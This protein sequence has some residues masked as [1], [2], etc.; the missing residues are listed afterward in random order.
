[1]KEKA[2]SNVL[3]KDI[4][5]KKI[6][7][8]IIQEVY[9]PGYILSEREL[10][11]S[12]EMSKTPIKSAIDRL[13]AEGFVYVSSKRGVIIQDISVERINDI[14]N[15]SIVLKTFNCKQIYKNI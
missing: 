14:Y 7:E 11:N 3:L 15:L 6:K 13:Q 4:A 10:V 8:N 9:Q 5:Y 1:M 12:L 2:N